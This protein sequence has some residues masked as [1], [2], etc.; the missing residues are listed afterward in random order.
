LDCHT[1]IIIR[2]DNLPKSL[3][4]LYCN[5]NKIESID[6]LPYNLIELN[7]SK[8]LINKLP[9]LGLFENLVNL[10]IKG[11]LISFLGNLPY[12]LRELNISNNKI[13]SIYSFGAGLEKIIN[14]DGTYSV[15]SR[16]N[17]FDLPNMLV[18]L[19]DGNL[20]PKM[21]DLYDLLVNGKYS[22]FI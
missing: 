16:T 18:S 13:C 11:N 5:Y 7:C 2:L 15:V 12:G 20:N 21:K 6:C 14:G 3:K 17:I 8:N 9:E 1:N 4:Y 19:L 22:N 10:N